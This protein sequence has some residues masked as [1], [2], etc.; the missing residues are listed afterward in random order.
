MSILWDELNYEN[1]SNHYGDPN[2]CRCKECYTHGNIYF[3]I[4]LQFSQN[5]V[6]SGKTLAEQVVENNNKKQKSDLDTGLM[7]ENY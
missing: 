2:F 6:F 1:K 5:L 4:Q 3:V 7:I